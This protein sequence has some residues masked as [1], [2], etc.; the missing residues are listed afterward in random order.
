MRTKRF[1]VL[2]DGVLSYHRKPPL[3]LEEASANSALHSIQLAEAH[4]VQRSR[5]FLMSCVKVED[6]REE[7][8]SNKYLPLCLLQLNT[9][10]DIL[11]F[12]SRSRA[13]ENTWIA[14]IQESIDKSSKGEILVE[15]GQ[16]ILI[17]VSVQTR[18]LLPFSSRITLNTSGSTSHL[19][20]SASP[21]TLR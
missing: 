17:T 1:L 21:S 7:V 4:T 14:A 16:N 6:N 18:S 15:V 19:H 11:W 5:H 12:R 13:E 10:N 9:E 20:S 2:R 8:P 3:S